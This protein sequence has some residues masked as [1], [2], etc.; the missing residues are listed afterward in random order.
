MCLSGEAAA[1]CVATLS[2]PSC[3]RP[4]RIRLGAASCRQCD[5]LFGRHEPRGSGQVV[6]VE[7]RLSQLA[8]GQEL[9]CHVR[10]DDR[11]RVARRRRHRRDLAPEF[12]VAGN[13]GPAALSER[14]GRL[15]EELGVESGT[16]LSSCVCRVASCASVGVPPR[17]RT[18]GLSST[19]RPS[20]WWRFQCR[21]LQLHAHGARAARASGR[22]FAPC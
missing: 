18:N 4:V 20:G 22:S 6:C 10:L 3:G 17:A 7:P 9:G 13:A 15:R 1:S 16:Q 19:P 14:L 11:L 12:A 2:S 5:C 8:H 21:R